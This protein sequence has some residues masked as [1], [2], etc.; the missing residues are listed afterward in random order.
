MEK[1]IELKS[2]ELADILG[3]GDGHIK[4]IESTVP[5][6]ITARGDLLTIK[7]KKSD[8]NQ[9]A[10][11]LGEMRGTLSSKGALLSDDVN[12]LIKLYKSGEVDIKSNIDINQVIYYGRKGAIG[13]RTNGQALYLESVINNDIVFGNGP[14]GT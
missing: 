5:V 3:I 14:A 11:I 13:P 9:A 8:I 7:G 6:S 12:N 2:M 1:I 10:A 4:L